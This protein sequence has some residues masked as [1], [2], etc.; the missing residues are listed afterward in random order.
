MNKKNIKTLKSEVKMCDRIVGFTGA[1]ISTESGIPDYRSKGGIWNRFQPV[2]FDEFLQDRN[3]RF[4]YWQRKR[5]IWD[6]IINAKPNDGHMFFMSLFEEG[7]LTGLITQNIDGLH[8]RSGL[9]SDKIINLHGNTLETICLK[10]GKII[11]TQQVFDRFDIYRDDPVCKKCGGLLKPNTISFGQNLNREVL[12]KAHY[13]CLNCD[14][15][16]V[17]G[18]TLLVQ[19]A[20]TLPETAKANGAQLA[21]IN[22]SDTPLDIETDY[23]FKMKI[24]DFIA[25]YN[26]VA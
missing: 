18:S 14:L 7:I 16:I 9:P 13:L 6:G 24:S 4:L 17:M 3:K 20:A 1:G 15:M 26:S 2:Y 22:M 21:I 10:C 11:P 8:E 23:L 19:P 25:E 12:K 5:E